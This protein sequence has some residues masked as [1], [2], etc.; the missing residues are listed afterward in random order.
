MHEISCFDVAESG[1]EMNQQLLNESMLF[2]TKEVADSFRF[3][4]NKKHPQDAIR[5]NVDPP[6]LTSPT[7]TPELRTAYSEFG[8]QFEDDV[9]FEGQAE[10]TVFAAPG[11]RDIVYA[12]SIPKNVKVMYPELIKKGKESKVGQ[13]DE[14]DCAAWVGNVRGMKYQGNAWHQLKS[15]DSSAI[16]AFSEIDNSTGQKIASLFSKMNAASGEGGNAEPRAIAKS[17]IPDQSSFSDLKMGDIVGMYHNSSEMFSKAFFEGQTGYTNLGQGVPQGD[18]TYMATEDDKVW[19]PSMLGSDIKFKLRWNAYSG[20]MNTH[21]G[22]VAGMIGEEPIIFHNVHG[23]VMASPLSS[24]GAG[25]ANAILWSRSPAGSTNEN[26]Q[27]KSRRLLI[28]AATVSVDDIIPIVAAREGAMEHFKID[29]WTFKILAAAAIAMA[30]R[31]SKF[32]KAHRYRG[33]DW[34]QSLAAKYDLPDPRKI[35][36]KKCVGFLDFINNRDFCM[37]PWDP[38]VGQTQT[39]WSNIKGHGPIPK[40]LG[41]YAEKIGVKSPFDLSDFVKAVLTTVGFLA[42]NYRKAKSADYNESMPGVNAGYEWS[43][44]GNAALDM[45]IVGYQAGPGRIRRYCGED[46]EKT[47][48]DCTADL[49]VKNY[50]PRYPAGK[51]NTLLYITQIARDFDKFYSMIESA[52]LKLAAALDKPQLASPRDSS[53]SEHIVQSGDTLGQIAVDYGVSVEEIQ[54][55]NDLTGDLI[56]PGQVLIIWETGDT[57]S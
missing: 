57:G 18:H 54:E 12:V 53:K 43:T 14:E 27:A 32:G 51:T 36:H 24:L 4:I 11:T 5:L 46:K 1:I 8:D 49:Q 56:K 26:K 47:W 22:I 6:R 20:G 2:Q 39:R 35:T 40:E 45:S 23:S 41:P 7:D 50:I 19:H 31:E 17:L 28:E 34:A 30:G 10:V 15:D 38:S 3:W 29:E 33:F 21:L 13:C 52:I 37:S 25:K 44:T 55:W 48:K 42:L 16:S 9:D